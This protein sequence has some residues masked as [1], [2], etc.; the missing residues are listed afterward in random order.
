MKFGQKRKEQETEIEVNA[1]A[2]DTYCF[3]VTKRV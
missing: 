3:E 2:F 1:K